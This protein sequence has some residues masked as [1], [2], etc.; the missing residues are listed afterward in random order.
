MFFIEIDCDIINNTLFVKS[1]TSYERLKSF[2]IKIYQNESLIIEK[3]DIGK[4][5][6]F[7]ITETNAPDD[8]TKIDYRVVVPVTFS[9]GELGYVATKGEAFAV[10]S[11]NKKKQLNKFSLYRQ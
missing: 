10:T 9:E 6:Y 8:Y 3:E 1:K 4:T 11:D 5:Y 7:V 2:R